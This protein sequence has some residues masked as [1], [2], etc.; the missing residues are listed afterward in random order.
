MPQFKLNKKYVSVSSDFIENLLPSANATFVKVYL[1]ALWLAHDGKDV[2]NSLI[3]ERLG[4][5]ESDVVQAFTYWY[6]KGLLNAENGVVEFLNFCE[7]SDKPVTE[8]QTAAVPPVQNTKTYNSTDVSKAINE[9]QSLSEMY[10]VA[11]ALLG[12]PLTTTETITLYSFYDWLGF[13]PEVILM[14]LDYCVSMGKKSMKYIEK[15]AISWHEAGLFTAEAVNEYLQKE[16][17]KSGYVYNVRKILGILDRNLTSVEEKY[18]SSWNDVYGMSEDMVALAYEY[19]VTQTSKL[20]MP[21]I[22][23]ILSRWKSE[24]IHTV[25]DA[26]KDNEAFRTKHMPKNL[27]NKTYEIYKSDGYDYDEI[28]RRMWENMKKR[29]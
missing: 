1:Y 11:Q 20:S 12:K 13:A 18:I 22:D 5:L 16:Q 3:A 6:K 14:L 29:D 2:D 4:I 8:Q 19:C 28:E 26:K 9:N 21:Y 27:Q 15:I 23:K 7:K 17:Q 10:M 25:E 24:G